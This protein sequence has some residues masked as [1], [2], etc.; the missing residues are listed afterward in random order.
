[1]VTN[2]KRMI[3]LKS[4]KF[5]RLTVQLEEKTN[6]TAENMTSRLENSQKE[7]CIQ[8]ICKHNTAIEFEDKKPNVHKKTM[9]KSELNPTFPY[10]KAKFNF[11][12]TL[13][14]NSNVNIFKEDYGLNNLSHF[15]TV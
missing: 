7:V 1:M 3:S 10:Q 15:G 2:G 5:C 4:A 12:S 8:L 9:V 6:I 14:T 13:N 11:N